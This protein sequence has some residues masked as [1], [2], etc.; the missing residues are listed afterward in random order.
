MVGRPK[1]YE[2][3]VSLPYE[4]CRNVFLRGSARGG[5]HPIDLRVNPVDLHLVDKVGSICGCRITFCVK[6][7]PFIL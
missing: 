3:K 4:S 5:R 7:V 6:P 1:I 2:T